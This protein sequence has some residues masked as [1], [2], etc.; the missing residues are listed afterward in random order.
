MIDGK[1]YVSKEIVIDNKP[2]LLFMEYLINGKLSFYFRQD[3]NKVNHYYASKDSVGIT[4]LEYSKQTVDHDGKSWED[5]NR[6]FQGLLSY[7]TYDCRNVS[8]DIR[9][10]N[11]PDH[12]KLIKFGLR[13]HNLICSDKS[14]IVFERKIPPKI[15]LEVLGGIDNYFMSIISTN[16]SKGFYSL[17]SLGFNLLFQQSENSE[18][19]YLGL[20]MV[21]ANTKHD[22]KEDLVLW[23]IPLSINYLDSKMGFSPTFSYAVD[24]NRF[25]LSQALRTG[26]KYQLKT[27]SLNLNAALHTMVFVLPY[28]AAVTT[29]VTFDLR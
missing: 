23:R 18:R 15:K 3:N 14:C 21:V 26:V 4:E 17:P 25:C 8:G 20:G 5:E 9:K 24:L 12:K 16:G 13:Y 11:E 10:M 1:Y 7:L 29:G 2:T 6:K 19:I 22:L 27:C 28:C